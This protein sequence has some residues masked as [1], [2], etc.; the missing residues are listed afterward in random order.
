MLSVWVS[1]SYLAAYGITELSKSRNDGTTNGQD[2]NTY[3]I[4]LSEDAAMRVGR[5][6]SETDIVKE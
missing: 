5:K 3:S 6:T 2:I 1:S 4:L